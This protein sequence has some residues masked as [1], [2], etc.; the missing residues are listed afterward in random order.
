MGFDIN[1]Q[2]GLKLEGG[3]Y[4]D[5]YVFDL[6]ASIVIKGDT[7]DIT[8]FT[9]RI[10]LKFSIDFMQDKLSLSFYFS[11]K[12]FSFYIY[13]ELYARILTKTLFE[14]QLEI[15]R[16]KSKGISPQYYY[17]DFDLSGNKYDQ[18]NETLD[19]DSFI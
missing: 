15:W 1:A 5:P 4:F 7:D 19:I 12:N 16:Y 14:K 11:V 3:I 6:H 13:L 2:V 18:F 9:G 8:L 17:F 10:G